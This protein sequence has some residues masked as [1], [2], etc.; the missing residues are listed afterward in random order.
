[1]RGRQVE[2]EQPEEGAGETLGL[3]QGQVEDCAQ[4]Q[5]AMDGGIGVLEGSAA[6]NGLVRT[7]P[8]IDGGLVN[9]KSE[10]STL[11]ES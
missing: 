7:K 9:P 8:L 5:A 10:T 2:V 6:T 11:S 4:Q 3:A 1:V